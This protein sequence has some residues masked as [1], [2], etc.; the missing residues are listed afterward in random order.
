MQK[1]KDPIGELL[2]KTRK[3][4]DVSVPELAKILSIPMARIYKWEQGESSPKY[5]DRIKLEAWINDAAWKNLPIEPPA[6][7]AHEDPGA[8]NMVLPLG[9]LVVTLKDYVELLKEKAKIVEEGKREAEKRERTLLALLENNLT[10]IKAN[11]I[12]IRDHLSQVGRMVRAD[13]LE[14]MDSLDR[15]EGREVGTSSTEAGIVEHGLGALNE[16]IDTNAAKG[17]EGNSG[18]VKQKRS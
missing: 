16:D 3:D 14:M 17:K 8:Y 13:D 12:T 1:T 5:Q 18:K 7:Q 9:D 4:R 10:E 6:S 2:L 11:S 15:L